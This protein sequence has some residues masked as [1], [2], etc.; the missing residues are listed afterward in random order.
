MTNKALPEQSYWSI[1]DLKT[2]EIVFD[3]DYEFTKISCDATSSFFNV[4]MNGLEPERYYK[5]VIKSTLADG[6]IIDWNN[7]LIFKVVK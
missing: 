7:D 3:F 4:Y 5:I 2:N 1:L 6:E